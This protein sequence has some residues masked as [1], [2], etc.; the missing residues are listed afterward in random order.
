MREEIRER[1]EKNSQAGAMAKVLREEIRQVWRI[2]RTEY[3][4]SGSTRT[5]K[6]GKGR[7]IKRIGPLT[8]LLP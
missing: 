5:G 2:K 4:H 3:N 8:P 6:V 1:I 7:R